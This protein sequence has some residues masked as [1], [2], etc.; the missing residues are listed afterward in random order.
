[1]R[2]AVDGTVHGSYG[3]RITYAALSADGRGA[4]SYGVI[5]MKL[6]D[7]TVS[8]RATVLETNSW[9][10]VRSRNL[11]GK[12]LPPGFL[13]IWTERHKLVCAKL[14]DMLDATTPADQMSSI[15]LKQAPNRQDEEFCEVHI[16]GT[17]TSASLES[18]SGSSKATKPI[19]IALFGWVKDKLAAIGKP[20]VEH[21]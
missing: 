2:L 13:S 8:E 6:R 9:T 11:F 20:W 10:F 5:S 3:E 12:M 7:V 21:D 18:I 19:D 16:F 14:L 17:F 15:I 4:A 1:M